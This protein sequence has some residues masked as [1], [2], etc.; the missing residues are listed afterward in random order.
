ML[1]GEVSRRSGVSVR[2]L[3]HYDALGLVHPT[4]RTSGG[5][6]EYSTADLRRLLH[7]ES[8]RTLGLSLADTTR[9][10]DD[11]EFTP[12]ELVGEMVRLT[13]RRIA[14]DEELLERLE[15]VDAAGPENWKDVLRVVALVRALGSESAAVRQRALLSPGETAPAPVEP[16]VE[17]VLAETDP[18]VAGALRW[19]LARAGADAADL[20]AGL[21]SES[22][23]VRRRAV[24][25]VAALD[26]P[27]TTA[28]LGRAL[29]D[30]D[31]T[32]RDDAA[33]ALGSRGVLPPGAA[34]AVLGVLV[35][36]VTEGRR[37]V[38]AAEALGLAAACGALAPEAV[39]G[40]LQD[41]F[42][43]AAGPSAASRITQAFAEIPGDEAV[44]ALTALTGDPDRTVSTTAAAILR[45][46]R[47]AS[48]SRSRVQR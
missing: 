43:H 22:A 33:L 37:D 12:S 6:R 42:A 46:R 27:A 39:V 31:P 17:A 9:A 36:M 47:R 35:G 4:G 23:A 24:A 15:R 25:A 41:A 18:N 20:A 10:L 21:A 8:L 30:R 19:S 34:A 5:Y 28:A 14:A 48:S 2:M 40:A 11:P 45:S 13:R 7:V 16:L 3:R 26:T 29:T 1:I 38:G 44:A 32:I